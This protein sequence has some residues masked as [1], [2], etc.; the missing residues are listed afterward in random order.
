[1]N[2]PRIR[3]SL[4]R[5]QSELKEIALVSFFL[6]L[7]LIVNVPALYAWD[8]ALMALIFSFIA[9]AGTFFAIDYFA[10]PSQAD[11]GDVSASDE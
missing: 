2:K 5:I 4:G 11:D 3:A 6:G 7:G 9:M 1:M 10:G 8:R